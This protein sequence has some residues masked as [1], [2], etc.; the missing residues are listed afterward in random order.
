MRGWRYVST[1]NP[2]W[3]LAGTLLMA[4]AVGLTVA[5]VARGPQPLQPSSD[6]ALMGGGTQG[7]FGTITEPMGH[8]LFVLTYDTITGQEED[9]QLQKVVGK[10]NEPQ[11]QWTLDAPAA[12]KVGGVWTLLGPMT[13]GAVAPDGRTQVGKGS[14][15]A[16]APALAWDKG[17]W[18]GLSP[19][20]WDD[21]QGSGR[22]RWNLPAGWH[23]G[24]DEKFVVDHGPVHWEAAQ[25]GTVKS[26]EAER[27]WTGMGF[28]EGHLE[29]VQAFLEGGSVRAKVVD[30]EPEWIRWSG[31]LSFVRDDGWHGTAAG[32]RAPRPPEGGAFEKVEFTDFEALRAMPGGGTESVRSDGARWSPAGL[33]LEGN[34][35]LEQP[36]DGQK[37]LLQAPRVL[38]RVAPAQKAPDDLPADLPVGE[39]WAEGQAVLTWGQRS[40]S[41]PRIEGR[42]KTRQWRIQAPA[43]GRSDQ[44]TFSA[45][46]GR[47]NPLRWEF[48]GPILAHFGEGSSAQ[49]DSLVWENNRYTFAGRPVTLT[50]FRQRLTGP[51]LVRQDDQVDF[52]VG[53]AGALAAQDGD[54]NL[55]ADRGKVGRTLVTL[56][57][58]VECRGQG[59][60]LQADR[61]SV[62]LTTG[63]MVKRVDANGA[64]FLKG[65][66]G[67]GRGDALALDP[68]EKTA[69]WTGRVKALTEVNP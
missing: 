6:P 66:M 45:G 5:Y 33:R 40:L 52:P 46:E 62:T 12:R 43:Q 26:M 36:L 18:H 58:R 19:L 20:V 11:T 7:R 50:R 3:R 67:E 17:V 34:V 13:I 35:R 65:R 47:G 56:D 2:V 55:Q 54:I 16:A 42:Q 61:I 23:R 14:I 53:I 69:N 48:D 41:S 28:R 29:A 59:W 8:G 38:Q 1:R 10:L 21:L 44:G 15:D 39:T 37:L 4:A 27:M 22:G 32:G 64:V 24:L 51:R 57:G 49:G 68:A 31:P 30:V 9:L 25:G 60:S 63:N